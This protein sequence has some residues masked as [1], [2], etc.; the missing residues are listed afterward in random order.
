[1]EPAEQPN[2][3]NSFNARFERVNDVIDNDPELKDAANNTN[4]N[5]AL[6]PAGAGN[7][8]PPVKDAIGED[9]NKPKEEGKD[10]PLVTEPAAIEPPTSWP[11]DDKEA[12]K[13]LPAWTQELIVRRDNEREAHFSERSRT[14][15]SRETE[16]QTIQAR[17]LQDQQ[18]Y[19]GE[20]QRLNQM[21]TQLMPAKF[22]DISSEADYLRLK[23]EDPARASEYE[24][25]VHVLRNSQSQQQQLMQQQQKEHL[26]KE[27]GMLQTKYPEFKDP[28]KGAALLNEVRKAAVDYY[29]FQQ[30]EVEIIADHRH[31]QIIRDALSWRNHQ[32]ALKAAEGK[33]VPNTP[34]QP[35][36]RT[37]AAGAGANLSADQKNKTLT[38]ASQETDL[39]KKADLLANLI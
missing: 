23:V 25:F 28:V 30:N 33:K 31:V 11:T 36:L 5:N 17:A 6:D 4:A 7:I 26:D 35:V 37:N 22:S 16:I 13:S 32:A 38:R 12:F 14:I 2:T 1:M 34:N 15:A 39:R 27:W 8:K 24:A 3:D 9:P 18:R 19:A 21:A 20:L 29:G 10:K